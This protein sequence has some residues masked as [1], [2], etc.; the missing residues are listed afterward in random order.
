MRHILL[1][2]LAIA[3]FGLLGCATANNSGTPLQGTYWKLTEIKGSAVSVKLPQREPHIVLTEEQRLAG[4]DGC[5]RLMGAYTLNGDKLVFSPLASTRMAC[6]EGAEYADL[7]GASLP[8]TATYRIQANQLELL[9]ASG[10]LIA[11]FSA[12][13]PAQ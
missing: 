4:S 10:A 6:M 3:L 8:Q 9:D 1:G 12:A 2:G 7:I 5:N 13:T 11:R